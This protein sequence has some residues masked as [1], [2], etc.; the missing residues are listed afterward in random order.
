MA[1]TPKTP[2]KSGLST[3]DGLAVSRVRFLT[4]EPAVPDRVRGP[5]LA[6]WQRSRELKVHADQIDLPYICD[7][8]VDSPLTRS[9]GPVLRNLH[10]QLDGQPV[11]IILTDPTGLVLTRL[12]ADHDLERH[13]DTVRL[14][15]GFSYGEQ[16]AGTNGIGTALEAGGPTH[17]FGHEHYA[18]NLEDL[19]C[20][21]VPIHHPVSGRTVGAVDLT[22]WRKDAGSLLLTLAKTT[23]EQIRQALLADTGVYQLELFHDYLRTCRRMSGIVFAVSSD[24]V[25][26]NDH[27]RTVLDPADQAALLAHATEALADRRHGAVT[28]G[29]PTGVTARMQF[30]PL[31]GIGQLAGVVVHVKLDD[32]QNKQT[33]SRGAPARLPLPELVGSAPLWLRACHEVERVFQSGEWLAVEGEPGVGKLALLRTV[34]L[35]GQ[36]AGRFVVLDAADIA[37]DPQ[38]MAAVRHTLL[39]DADN[40]AIRH[41]D[42]LDGPQLRTLSC[43]LQDARAAERQRP[44]WVAVT[45]HNTT[46]R[47]DL[48]HLMRLFPSTVEVPPLRLHLEDLQQLVSFFLARLG[49]GGQLACSPAAM[50]LLMRS[51]WP[52]NAEQLQQMLRQVVQHRR[53]GSIE[54]EDLP[55]EART[56]SRRLLSPLE[57]MERDAIVRSLT[58]AG[59]NKL[60]A[61]GS[62]G[63]SRAT[64]YRKIREYGIVPA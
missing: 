7:P 56:V 51:P 25:L 64:I 58:D 18:E 41:V 5:I 8:D 19:A 43:A 44:L 52:G 6:S 63:M 17:V 27:A 34:Q 45:L 46:G 10:E 32:S 12:T 14:A 33:D 15:P 61:A 42:I 57:S 20:A 48:A 26:L 50:R 47:T 3:R 23:A 11:S 55:P 31:H 60:A 37:S 39:E 2:G 21:G 54:P 13:L 29:L 16:Y 38:W 49:H 36:Q 28:V 30:R 59:G 4:A 24:M 22:C 9:A 35:R 53:T 62:L 40:V 1:M